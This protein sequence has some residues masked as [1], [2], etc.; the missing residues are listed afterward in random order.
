MERVLV[1][2]LTKQHDN[3]KSDLKDEIDLL[4][5]EIR[6]W[7]V[8]LE[9]LKRIKWQAIGVCTIVFATLEVG[10]RLAGLVLPR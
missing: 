5:Q 3:L 7:K 4:R 2:L 6:E 9:D 1:E 10:F 8:E